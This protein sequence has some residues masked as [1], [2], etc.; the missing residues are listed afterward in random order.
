MGNNHSEHLTG[1]F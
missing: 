1:A